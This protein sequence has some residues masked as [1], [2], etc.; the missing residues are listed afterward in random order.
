M[1]PAKLSNQNAGEKDG[2]NQ[3][4]EC[5]QTSLP[6]YTGKQSKPVPLKKMLRSAKNHKCVLVQKVI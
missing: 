6:E 1:S 3:A 2:D 5:L 4:N